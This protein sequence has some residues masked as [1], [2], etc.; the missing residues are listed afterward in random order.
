MIKIKDSLAVAATKP[1]LAWGVPA[2][3]L[4]MSVSF[5]I[6][7]GVYINTIFFNG[8]SPGALFITWLVIFSL[9]YRTALYFTR[10]DVNF[11]SVFIKALV[12]TQRIR[13]F[14]FWGKVNTYSVH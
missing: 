8:R 7:P 4:L 9:L 14:K 11:I 1:T 5:S 6:L 2:K 13:N 10:K 3:F 12:L